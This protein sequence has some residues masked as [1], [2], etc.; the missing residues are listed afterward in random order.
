MIYE[1][2]KVRFAGAVQ[3]KEATESIL[4]REEQNDY[5]ALL[6][7]ETRDVIIVAKG[8]KD[9]KKAHKSLTSLAA[10]KNYEI[11]DVFKSQ[12][13]EQIINSI[14][15]NGSETKKADTPKGA[16]KKK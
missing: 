12:D 2:R 15:L 7:S 3:L 11:V 10:I 5:L 9:K 13:W 6:N 4:V 16:S 14:F 8:V 1:I